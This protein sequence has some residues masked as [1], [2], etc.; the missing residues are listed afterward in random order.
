MYEYM[1]LYLVYLDNVFHISL[2]VHMY[3]YELACKF[4]SFY[5][6]IPAMNSITCLCKYMNFAKNY[7]AKL[8]QCIVLLLCSMNTEH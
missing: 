5:L 8:S 2:N 7:L 3:N 4:G 1:M 6:N